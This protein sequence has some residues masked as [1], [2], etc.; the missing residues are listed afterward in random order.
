MGRYMS[1]ASLPTLLCI[2]TQLFVCDNEKCRCSFQNKKPLEVFTKKVYSFFKTG[3]CDSS[4]PIWF[5]TS[6]FNAKLFIEVSYFFQLA[7]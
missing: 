4:F 7:V 1:Y 2:L 6:A 3:R 5:H